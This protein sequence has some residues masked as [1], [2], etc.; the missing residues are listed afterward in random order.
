MGLNARERAALDRWIMNPPELE[1][2]YC[3]DGR[4]G[5]CASC[6]AEQN[7]SDRADLEYE[8]KRD[9]EMEREWERME[10]EKEGK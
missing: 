3:E 6:H 1:E 2:E 7:E 4:C 5:E 8:R 9:R 10:K